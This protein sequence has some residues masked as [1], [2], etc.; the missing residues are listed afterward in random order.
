[1]AATNF[2]AVSKPLKE[3]LKSA[4]LL[5]SLK[6]NTLISG[7]P[8]TG[9]HTLARVMMPDAPILHGD[10]PDLYTLLEKSP[11]CI[12]DRFEAIDNYPRFFQTLRK[13]GVHTIAIAEEGMAEGQGGPFSVRITLPPLRERPEDIDPLV[14]KFTAEIAELF[15]E[16]DTG[17]TVERERLDI[18]RNGFSLRKSIMLQ[19]LASDI[20]EADLLDLN[21]KFLEKRMDDEE[22]YRR[23][24]YLYE[25]PLIRAGT[26]RYKSQLGMSRVFG[27]NRN[28]L[29]KKIA[30]WRE[31][32]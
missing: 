26:R 19:Y 16:A 24:L 22:L 25:V 29:R 21:E 2:I 13:H 11:Q 28:T 31:Y 20:G 8:G 5:K 18:S 27:L 23:M 12:V 32:L 9:R 30:E 1:V 14:E 3:A 6:L 17:F 4:N 10:H 7:E 15:G